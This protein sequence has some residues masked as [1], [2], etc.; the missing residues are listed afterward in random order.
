M[1]GV[2]VFEEDF[3]DRVPMRRIIGRAAG[4]CASGG[5]LLPAPRPKAFGEEVEL[6]FGV[7][8]VLGADR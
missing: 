5:A 3:S 4:R 8:F 2:S 7:L 1:D 6:A